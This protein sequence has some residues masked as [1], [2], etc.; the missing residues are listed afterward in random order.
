LNIVV[1][2]PVLPIERGGDS[3]LIHWMSDSIII[4]GGAKWVIH[5]ASVFGWYPYSYPSAVA[6]LNAVFSIIFLDSRHV[7]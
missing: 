6:H 5:P 4:E 1:R 7:Y 3:S 2:I